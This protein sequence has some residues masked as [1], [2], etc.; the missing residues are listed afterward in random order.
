MLKKQAA[1]I[2]KFINEKTGRNYRFVDTN[3][4]FI[5]ARLQSGASIRD[6]FQVIAKKT[7]QWKIVLVK[8]DLL[9][10]DDKTIFYGTA[11]PCNDHT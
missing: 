11:L 10:P 3:L 8:N 6:C 9:A 2:L 7:R 4:K 1:E 5:I